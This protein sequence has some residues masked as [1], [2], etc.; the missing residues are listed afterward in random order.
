MARRVWVYPGQREVRWRSANWSSS[1][2]TSSAPYP[3]AISRS[4]RKSRRSQAIWSFRD[5]PVWSRS[6][7]RPSRRVSHCST[8]EWA[9]SCSGRITSR[10]RSTARSAA[11]SPSR[12][13]RGAEEARGAQP[14]HVTQAPQHVEPDEVAVPVAVVADGEVEEAGVE[15][16]VGGPERRRAGRRNGGRA[17]GPLPTHVP[18]FR[19]S[20]FP[21]HDKYS[22]ASL[23]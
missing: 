15:V 16:A 12:S 20:A 18:P 21:P 22:S 7:V 9:S 2:A 1:A 10:P 13:F 4:L 14:F 5:R 17:D 3:R 6:P 23:A 8:A 19:L 11:L